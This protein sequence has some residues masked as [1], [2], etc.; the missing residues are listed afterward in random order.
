MI[1]WAAFK[2]C[3]TARHYLASVKNINILKIKGPGFNEIIIHSLASCDEIMNGSVLHGDDP[4]STTRQA[5]PQL[6]LGLTPKDIL[7]NEKDPQSEDNFITEED[8]KTE[9]YPKTLL[10]EFR[11]L[12]SN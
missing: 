5:Q 6:L 3:D 9:D 1:F 11:W 4:N 10:A 12:F 8:P 2:L 7:K